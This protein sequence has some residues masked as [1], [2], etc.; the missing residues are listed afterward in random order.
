MKE[1]TVVLLTSSSKDRE[2]DETLALQQVLQ[3]RFEVT[4]SNDSIS[5][6]ISTG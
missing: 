4:L 6:T 3:K 5:H 1:F 2:G